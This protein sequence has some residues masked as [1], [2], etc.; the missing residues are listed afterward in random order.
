MIRTGRWWS[1]GVVLVV[2]L[3]ASVGCAKRGGQAGLV[4][5][6]SA[7]GVGAVEAGAIVR[8]SPVQLVYVAPDS[9][10]RTL[11]VEVEP[12]DDKRKWTIRR[13]LV[14]SEKG[15][16]HAR[17][18]R[19]QIGEW[20]ED[21]SLAVSREVNHEEGVTV[22]FEPALV[23]FPVMVESEVSR[24][25]KQELVMTVHPIADETKVRAKGRVT[26]TVSFTASQRVRVPA[27]VLKASQVT[28]VFE[29]SLSG[30]SVR[31]ET[32]TWLTPGV[33]VVAEERSERT[34]LLGVPIRQNHELWLLRAMPAK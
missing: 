26:Q 21:G 25:F 14:T 18:V 29:A 10:E 32:T 17:L 34:T 5:E 30:T 3:C 24:A 12:A 15:Q 20:R 11:R 2:T 9:D 7:A 4:I 6:E 23:V 27:G 13:T 1:A 33:G 8:A 22:V 16:Q 28:S 19:E 31:N